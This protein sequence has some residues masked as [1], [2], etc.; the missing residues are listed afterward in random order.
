MCAFNCLFAPSYF[1]SS[2]VGIEKYLPLV[3]L[4]LPRNT[5]TYTH[6]QTVTHKHAINTF[7]KSKNF[8]LVYITSIGNY[9]DPRIC[10]NDSCHG[11]IYLHYFIYHLLWLPVL[12]FI[13]NPFWLLI[14]VY[15][16][17]AYFTGTILV[18]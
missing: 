13:D 10:I 5:H 7:T 18:T 4:L 9:L 15:L 12:M 8:F 17:L 11:I 6:A 1:E 3:V 16:R 14:D 2:P